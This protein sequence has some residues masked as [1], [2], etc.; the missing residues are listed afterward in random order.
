MF[1]TETVATLINSRCGSNKI[2]KENQKQI[3]LRDSTMDKVKIFF[4]SLETLVPGRVTD[5]LYIARKYQ[6]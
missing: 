1:S 2:S 3:F 4:F 5:L 6:I